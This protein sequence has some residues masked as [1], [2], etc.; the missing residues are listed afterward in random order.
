[1]TGREG[2]QTNY[3]KRSRNHHMQQEYE[4]LWNVLEVQG[5]FFVCFV[6]VED[7]LELMIIKKQF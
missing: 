5:M 1:M 7:E 2:P 6:V 3:S 4:K